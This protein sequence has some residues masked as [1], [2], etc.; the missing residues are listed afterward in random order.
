MAGR[1]AALLLLLAAV[2]A[3]V[4][5]QGP[6]PPLLEYHFEQVPSV[7]IK[8]EIETPSFLFSATVRCDAVLQPSGAVLRVSFQASS[9]LVVTGPETV[10]L[11]PNACTPPATSLT[12][13][14]GYQIAIPRTAPGLQ[15]IAVVGRAY[16]EPEPPTA[17]AGPGNATPQTFAVTPDYYSHNQVK[18]PSKLRQCSPCGHV[19]VEVE[20]TNFG[21][22]RTQYTFTVV[23][24]PSSGWDLHL[25][26]AL[27]LDAQ[28]SG[29]AVL[30]AGGHGGE[31]SFQVVVRPSAAADPQKQGDPLTF[32]FLVRDT[33][34]ASRA[35]PA[36]GAL[37][38]GLALVGLAL[39]RRRA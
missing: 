22:A 4:A 20:I 39:S 12:V 27:L 36:P 13:Q 29:K 10:L 34:L 30:E 16:L 33:S 9:G 32:N 15:A 6:L 3:P 17:A 24:K 21:N 37:L 18:V 23:N 35:S 2:A 31:A 38:S 14:Q 25:P 1:S 11:D 7:P 19:P 8:P 26:D 5:A 28:A